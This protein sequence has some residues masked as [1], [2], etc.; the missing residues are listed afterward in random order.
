MPEELRPWYFLWN[1]TIN[2]INVAANYNSWS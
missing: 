2:R 1:I